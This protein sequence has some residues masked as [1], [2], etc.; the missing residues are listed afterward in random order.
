MNTKTNTFISFSKKTMAIAICMVC[1]LLLSTLVTTAAPPPGTTTTPYTVSYSAKLADSVG[2]PITTTQQIRFSLWSDADVDPTDY[3]GSGA[4]DPLAGGFSGWRETHNV[5]PDSNGLFHLQLGSI[6]TLPNFTVPNHIYL[7]VDVKANGAPDTS[8]ETLDPDGN[9][10][11][12]TDRHPVNSTAFA[13]NS[14]TVDNRDVG[15]N[16]GEIPY[17]DG[18]AQLPVSTI[19]GGTDED[20]F[21]LDFDNSV[22]APGTISLQFGGTLAK[23]LEYDL[24]A[25]YFNFNDHVN[26]S[27]DLTVTGSADFSSSSEFHM[28]EVADE[29]L[30]DCT[31]VDELVLD[32]TENR[33]Y[34]CS[35]PGSPGTWVA[36]S[37]TAGSSYNQSISFEPEYDGVVYDQ[38][39]TNNRGKLE[40][41]FADTD[42]V[43]GNG[44]YNYYLWTTRNSSRQD[45]DLTI[46]TRI[47]EGFT[48]W[49]AVPVNFTY[50]T[51]TGLLADNQIDITIEDTNGNPVTLT[52]ASALV[53]TAWNTT[54]I[55]YAGAPVWAPGQPITIKIKLSATSAGAAYAGNLKLNYA[56]L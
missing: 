48:G 28:R 50:R 39:G 10:A 49:Q 27:G 5:T 37:G 24:A 31:T 3:L 34:S 45:I 15:L 51:Q 38:D 32:T 19:P 22:A 55:T 47:P 26:V 36:V 35:S 53:N 2:T 52:G 16:A 30:A 8:Y 56:G 29:A 17:L 41:K 33:I 21:I 44:N 18:S 40:I 1:V 23:S 14:D 54:N 20:S 6:N 7:Q 12:L 11:N 9:T 4:I 43:P 13:I 46:R 42:G 25:N